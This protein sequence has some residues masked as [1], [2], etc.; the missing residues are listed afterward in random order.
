M[1]FL[2][3]ALA[4]IGFLLFVRWLKQRKCRY[5]ASLPPGPRPI[6]FFGNLGDFTSS[7][8]WLTVTQWAKKYGEVC[9]L[10]VLGQGIVFLN[11]A[12]AASDLLDKRGAIYSDRPEQ[13]MVGDLCGCNRLL[14]FLKY[15]SERFTRQ[16]RF[17][18]KTL[19]PRSIPAYVPMIRASTNAFLC[20]MISSPS[21]Y[22]KHARKYAGGLTL[23]V[24]YGYQARNANDKFLRQA[25]VCLDIITNDIIAGSGIWPVDLI[26]VLGYLPSWMPG[27]GFKKKAAL[28]NT[29]LKEFAE[30]PFEEAK[31]AV[32][33]GTILPSFCSNL[34]SREESLT[35]ADEEEVKYCAN[36]MFAA[37]A[38]TTVTTTSQFLLAMML[39][40]EVL[41]KAQSEIDRVVGFDRLPELGDKKALPYVNA[42]MSEVWRWGVPVPLN[43]PHC[44]KQ[45]DEYRGMH[46]PKG[47]IVVANIWAILRDKNL[48]PHPEV[49]D[50]ERFMGESQ[51]P[52]KDPRN[53]IFGFGR[54]RC[55]GADLVESSIWLLLASMIAS[56][57]IKKLGEDQV[58]VKYSNSFF[59]V[60]DR[61]ACDIKPRSEKIKALLEVS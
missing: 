5:P 23:S 22:L 35:T 47:S 24:V 6:P 30:D 58:K 2:V 27:A 10:H 29:M 4:S 32:K 45:D 43:I 7:E 52:V 37:S 18:K 39:H 40:P 54:R 57:D 15:N 59:R 8:P 12:D 34:L 50:P 26:P 61:L 48:Y 51:D 49:F 1:T 21:H 56:L 55:P 36:S 3:V 19:G 25:E 42:V 11:S 31:T 44:L 38:D 53:Y 20:E 41:K 60:P 28:W 13:K 17:V 9:Y 16:Q 46:I 14:P 33:N